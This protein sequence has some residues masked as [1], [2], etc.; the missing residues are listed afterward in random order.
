MQNLTPASFTSSMVKVIAFAIGV[1]FFIWFLYTVI[2]TVLLFLLA[3]VSVVLINAPVTWLQ[4]KKWPRPLA[5]FIVLL[6]IF[7]MLVLLAW[8]IIPIIITQ[9]KSLIQNLP[10]YVNNIEKQL[11]FWKSTY[12]H[13]TSEGGDKLTLPSFSNTLSRLGG[14]SVSVVEAVLLFLLL[15]SLIIYMVLY[16]RPLLEFYLSLF[17]FSQRDKA[18]NAYVKTAT[19]IRGWMRANLIGGAVEAVSVVIFLNLMNVPGAWVWGMLALV[20]QLIPKIGFFLMSVPPTLVAFSL[21]PFTAFWV[22]VFYLVLAEI[23]GDFI[24]PKLRST[25]MNLHPVAIILALLAMGTAFGFIGVLLAT[26]VAACLK[27]FY[28]E[29]YLSRLPKDEKLEKRIDLMMGR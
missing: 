4:K 20:S 1:I 24:M 23:V 11:A 19:M 18:T 15:I 14:I 16:P 17:P 7:V 12:F 28:E 10:V 13:W 5:L 3:I 27:A 26:P 2:S 8:L 22:F 9:L 25:S 6:L 21:S 29:F